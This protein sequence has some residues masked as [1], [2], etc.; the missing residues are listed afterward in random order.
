MGTTEGIISIAGENFL[1][2]GSLGI[3]VDLSGN[4][5]PYAPEF[6][7]RVGIAYT[8]ALAGYSA[9]Y[10]LDYYW[11][12]DFEARVY[13]AGNDQIDSWD[14]LDAVAMLDNPGRWSLQLYVKNLFNDDFV[15]GHALTDPVAG[16][17]RSVSVLEPRTWGA[18]LQFEF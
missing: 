16:L 4:E 3:P 15:T 1:A 9:T 5:L 11:Q 17:Y 2:D 13:N 8:H 12:D 10:M 6:S 14:V 7:T 18:R